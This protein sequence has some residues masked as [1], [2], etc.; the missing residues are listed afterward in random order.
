MVSSPHIPIRVTIDTDLPS[1]LDEAAR[2]PLLLEHDGEL[3]RLARADDISYEPN[4]VLIQETLAATA[5]SLAD[6]DVD[7]VVADLFEARR[8]GSR[9]PERP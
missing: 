1:L 2:R 9:P 8:A 7:H 4:A 3:F 5:G 6:L